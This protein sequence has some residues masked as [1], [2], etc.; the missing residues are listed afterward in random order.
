[1]SGRSEPVCACTPGFV[2]VSK[3]GCVDS[4][5]PIL[6]L[7]QDEG[8][9]GVTILK[10]GDSYKEYA[11]DVR[12]DNAEDYLRSLKIAYSRP[13]PAGCHV[14]MG[15]FEVNYTVVSTPRSDQTCYL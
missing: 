11:V 2:Q 7:R 1:M 3:Y 12:D 4:N 15:T 13:L 6:K 14:E 8:G 9:D 10:Q 5:P